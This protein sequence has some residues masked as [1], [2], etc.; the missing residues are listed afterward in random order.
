[1]EAQRYE[2]AHG[3]SRALEFAAHPL[4]G[5]VGDFAAEAPLAAALRLETM[6]RQGELEDSK[7]VFQSLE[8]EIENLILSLWAITRGLE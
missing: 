7:V 2:I 3:D 4:K 1:M 8:I 6:G 5:S